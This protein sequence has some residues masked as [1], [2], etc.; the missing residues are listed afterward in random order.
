MNMRK[1]FALL[2]M[3][4][5]CFCQSQDS[6]KTEPKINRN[7]IQITPLGHY[8]R[9]I[10]FGISYER[11]IKNNPKWSLVFPV[12]VGL[13][14]TVK[15]LAPG[16][17]VWKTHHNLIFEALPGVK[18]YPNPHKKFTYALGGNL[19]FAFEDGYDSNSLMAGLIAN[20]YIQYQMNK[21]F[22]LGLN[23]GLGIS[24]NFRTWWQ[25]S[26][27]DNKQKRYVNTVLP[28]VNAG[29]NLGYRF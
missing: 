2:F 25:S 22:S 5:A 14:A 23:A 17:T 3:P 4:V 6:L 11:I 16:E 26:Y 8:F 12:G 18:F 7:I 9:S 13:A 21:G 20:N 29:I 19:T 27:M 28:T 15:T 24:H 1:I 10:G